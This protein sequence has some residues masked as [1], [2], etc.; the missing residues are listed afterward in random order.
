VKFFSPMSGCYVAFHKQ[1]GDLVLLEPALSR[2][3]GHHGEPVMLMTRNGHAD[4]VELM[5]GVQFVKGMPLRPADALYCF[6]PLTKSSLRSALAPAGRRF[7]IAPEKRESQ[8]FHPLLFSRPTNPDLRDSYIA[9]YFWQHTPVPAAMPFRPPVLRPPP[10]EWAPAGW[11]PGS[12]VLVNATSGW[13]KKMWSI[14][15]WTSVLNAL[16]RDYPCVLTSVGS[17]WQKE[18]CEAIASATGSV[19]QPTTMRQ[20]L[21]LCA[22]ARAVLTVDGAA[23]HLASA[24]SVPCLTIFGP[25]SLAHWHRPA[26]NHVAYQAP[27][28]NDGKRR[29]RKLDPAPVIEAMA[30]L[31]I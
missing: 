26:P 22:N 7:L 16:P 6:D 8:W 29:L 27:P 31:G 11:E 30:K 24:F 23:S 10:R 4:V 12:Y 19:L 25:T 20:F 17:G 2:L 21:W 3:R 28:D 5:E 9:E 13:K 15:G 18:H 14:K 1:L